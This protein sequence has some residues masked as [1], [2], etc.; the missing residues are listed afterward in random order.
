M[1]VILSCSHIAKKFDQTVVLKD[2]SF[3][4]AKGEKIGLIGANGSGKSTLLK[5]ITKLL[6]KDGGVINRSKE[7][8]I[9]HLPQ[10]HLQESNLSGGE[11]A[12]KVLAPI[13][14]S[15][16]DLFLL[17]EPTNNLDEEGLEMIESFIKKSSK[18]FLIVSHDRMFLDNIVSK[19]IE[20]DSQNQSSSIYEGNYS[21]YLAHREAKIE[22]LWKEY[23]DKVE[24]AEKLTS[25]VKERLSWVKEIESKRFGIKNL[26][27]HEK[28]KPQ[29]AILRDK[30]GRAGRRAAVMKNR[31]EK[32]EAQ[33]DDV[34][35]PHQG[36]PL[37]VHFEMERGST[38]VFDLKQVEKTVGNRK[39]GPLDLRVNFGDRLHLI[40]KNGTGKTTLLKMLLGEMKTD[41]GFLE[42]GQN[43]RIGYISQERWLNRSSKKVIDDFLEVTKI[44]ETQARELLNR[45]RITTE[46]VKKDLG[47]L[48]PGEYSRLLIAELVALRPNL[49]I[50]DEP[51]N[52]LDLEVLSELEKGLA[53][54]SGT[55]IVVSH[56]RYFVGKIGLTGQCDLDKYSSLL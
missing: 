14:A 8:R 51:S 50:L 55:L 26:P 32:Y 15:E 28:E 29:A 22:R 16:A 39:I 2:V 37:K 46:D 56:D 44:P 54:Y 1:N 19:I 31:L 30:E 10:V 18:S 45:F 43:V 23:N 25:S 20:I 42:K 47:A 36:L 33:T 12:K 5:I 53:E 35:K 3:T 4:I 7:L 49:I 17:D 41:A 38:K 6:E 11:R 21:E 24:K 13:V 34:K 27:I 40:G 52:H 48:S 9:E